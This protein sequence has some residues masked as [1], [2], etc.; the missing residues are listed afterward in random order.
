MSCRLVRDTPCS[1]K[2][3]SAVSRMRLRVACASSFVRRTMGWPRRIGSRTYIHACM[4]T[5]RPLPEGSFSMSA[6]NQVAEVL[7]HA[8]RAAR[9]ALPLALLVLA[10]CG[11]KDGPP[12]GGAGAGP[13]GGAPPP[14]EVGVVSVAPRAVRLV[15]ALSGR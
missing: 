14:P 6:S 12:G 3:I 5:T 15:T 7:A 2:T 4:Y 8:A 11:Q 1:W 9:V 10:G 13:G